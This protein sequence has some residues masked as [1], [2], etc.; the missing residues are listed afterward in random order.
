MPDNSRYCVYRICGADNRTHHN[1]K[2][3]VFKK[4][5]FGGEGLVTA[6]AGHG[7]KDRADAEAARR[8]GLSNAARGVQ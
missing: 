6:F 1:N 5:R 2:W 8:N 4:S 3:G 7:A